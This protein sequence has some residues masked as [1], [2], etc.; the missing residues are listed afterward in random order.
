M[1]KMNINIDELLDKLENRIIPQLEI[2]AELAA[3]KATETHY[4]YCAAERSGHWKTV[5]GLLGLGASFLGVW[6][7][8]S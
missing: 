5:F 4:K 8:V 7:A 1:I 6:A 3:M 2:V